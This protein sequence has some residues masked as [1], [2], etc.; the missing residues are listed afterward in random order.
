MM[1][2][3]SARGKVVVALCVFGLAS[4]TERVQTPVD[5]KE[6]ADYR[7]TATV[8][9]Q[10]EHASRLIAEVTRNDPDFVRAPLFTREVAVLGDAPAMAT[11]LDVRLRNHP[12]LAKAVD[13]AQI[14]AREYSKFAIALLAARLAYGFVKA[15]VLRRVPDGVATDNLAFVASHEAEV[16][17]VLKVM[18][19][20]SPPSP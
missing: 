11:G 1:I 19:I 15:G 9:R 10:F 8:F 18:G 17:T 20:E 4:P 5:V 13:T 16:T 6:L 7:L 12:K 3:E 2:G 14:G